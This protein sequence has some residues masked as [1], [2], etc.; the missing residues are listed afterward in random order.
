MIRATLVYI[1]VSLYVL[2]MS[3]I[4][5]L[6]AWLSGD[7]PFIYRAG[8]FC[9]YVAGWMSGVKVLVRGKEMLSPGQTYLF[10][11]NHQGNL[12][13]PIII[14]V[15]GRELR[16]LF[17]KEM[18]RIP[19][20]PLA[21]KKVGFLPIDRTDPARA[22]ACLDEGAKMLKDGHS[23]FAFPEGTRS[24]DGCLGPFKKG[25]FHMALKA[26]VPIVPVS[27]KN[28]NTIQPRGK[29]AIRPGT[30][31]V[32]FHDPIPTAQFQFEDRARLIEATR[33][34]IAAGLR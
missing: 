10:L 2:I 26:G 18:M 33:A 11:S 8:R 20:L 28:T 24:R 25:V 7:A 21:M 13:A 4:A 34:A 6:W 30:I 12:D 19:V 5:F 27:I 32:T 1:F 22:H 23:F 14:C 29:Y 17:K 16:S 15:A 31:E 3:P 9:L